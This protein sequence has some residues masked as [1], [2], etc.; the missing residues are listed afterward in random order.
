MVL[1][2]MANFA[3][4]GRGARWRGELASPKA[5]VCSGDQDNYDFVVWHVAITPKAPGQCRCWHSA[6]DSL[7]LT[8]IQAFL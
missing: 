7:A 4:E 1:F 8:E 3:G 2:G 6:T 5:C